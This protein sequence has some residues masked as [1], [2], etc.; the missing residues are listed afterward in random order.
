MCIHIILLCCGSVR[1]VYPICSLLFTIIITAFI[2][3][4]I[5]FKHVMKIADRRWIR[6]L[7][8]V[9]LFAGFISAYGLMMVGSFQVTKI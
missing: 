1:L 4:H 5:Y 6:A 2:I 7:N 3:V 8:Y 9:A